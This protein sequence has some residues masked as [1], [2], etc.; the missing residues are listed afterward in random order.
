MKLAAN[1]QQIDS[2]SVIQQETTQMAVS[3]T[4]HMCKQKVAERVVAQRQEQNKHSEYMKKLHPHMA[5]ESLISG[6]AT[7]DDWNSVY[8]RLCLMGSLAK[9]NADTCATVI[10][11]AKNAMLRIRQCYEFGKTWHGT[12]AEWLAV[13]LGLCLS[14]RLQD[15]YA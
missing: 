5:L 12:K 11:S 15:I 10:D 1:W 4:L 6:Q 13:G 2:K 3:G 7:E 9:Q 14:D 8:K